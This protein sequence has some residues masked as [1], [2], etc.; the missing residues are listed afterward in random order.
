MRLKICG[1]ISHQTITRGVRLIETVVSEVKQLRPE[2]FGLFLSGATHFLSTFNK[3]WLH[4]I[5]QVD[6]LFT[7]RLT[8]RICLTT[9]KATPFLGDLH[10]LLLINQN[11]VSRFQSILETRVKISN[12]FFPVLTTN[13][14]IDKL[15]RA[16]TIKSHH[17]DNIFKTTGAKILQITLHTGRF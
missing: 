6:L 13:K 4:L 17:S 8:K 2:S 7:H 9:S 12:R 16:R 11:T 14:R 5:H 15:H 10:E 3:L 1:P